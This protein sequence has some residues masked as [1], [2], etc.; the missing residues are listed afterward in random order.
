MSM[1]YLVNISDTTAI[2]TL[3]FVWNASMRCRWNGFTIISRKAIKLRYIT[4]DLWKSNMYSTRK[5]NLHGW[6]NG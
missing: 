5:T 3:P 4:M 6:K 2:I 1:I